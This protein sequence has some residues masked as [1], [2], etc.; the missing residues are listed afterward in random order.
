MVASD[1]FRQN[2][3]DTSVAKT[4][5][6]A[7]STNFKSMNS[8]MGSSNGFKRTAGGASPSASPFATPFYLT[9]DPTN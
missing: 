7:N 8:T 1:Y 6:R 3:P 2:A 4:Q 9:Q 5:K